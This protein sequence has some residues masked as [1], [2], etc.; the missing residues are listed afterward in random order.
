MKDHVSCHVLPCENLYSRPASNISV[1]T[2][3]IADQT[4]PR[5]QNRWPL[6]SWSSVSFFFGTMGRR[7]GVEDH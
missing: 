5:N 6:S 7:W 2:S 3:M 1:N 4:A